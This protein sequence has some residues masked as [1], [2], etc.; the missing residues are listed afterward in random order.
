MEWPLLPSPSTATFPSPRGHRTDPRPHVPSLLSI[1]PAQEPAR[2]VLDCCSH[3]FLPSQRLCVCVSDGWLMTVIS[4][5]AFAAIP[6][7]S[8]S[9]PSNNNT[10]S[11]LDLSIRIEN[12]LSQSRSSCQPCHTARQT[13]ALLAP[14]SARQIAPS[15]ALN[16]S[17]SRR[18]PHPSEPGCDSALPSFRR[19]PTRVVATGLG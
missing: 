1:H 14:L 8:P 15:L 3:P 18:I 6:S 19:L 17:V 13:F 2:A 11:K 9:P 5:P 4:R 12:H 16:R 7:P 10:T